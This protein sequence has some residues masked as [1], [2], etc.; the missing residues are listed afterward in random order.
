MVNSNGRL[1]MRILKRNN[2]VRHFC[3]SVNS[4]DMQTAKELYEQVG[5][6]IKNSLAKTLDCA[7]ERFAADKFIRIEKIEIDLGDIPRT[8]LMTMLPYLFEQKIH[9]LFSGFMT[10]AWERPEMEGVEVLDEQTQIIQYFTHFL[11]YGTIPWHLEERMETLSF[12]DVLQVVISSGSNAYHDAF[13][14]MLG[15]DQARKR[16]LPWVKKVELLQILKSSLDSGAYQNILKFK[17][18]LSNMVLSAAS[19]EYAEKLFFTQA[20]NEFVLHTA[21]ELYKK[22]K[23]YSLARLTDEFVTFLS[24]QKQLTP[25]KWIKGWIPRM[26]ID[27]QTSRFEADYTEDIVEQILSHYTRSI[28]VPIIPHYDDVGELKRE[29]LVMQPETGAGFTY[30]LQLVY[31]E[32]EKRIPTKHQQ[33][34]KRLA[35][36][37]VWEALRVGHIAQQQFDACLVSLSKRI[38]LIIPLDTHSTA[39]HVIN[40]SSAQKTKLGIPNRTNSKNTMLEAREGKKHNLLKSDDKMPHG[41]FGEATP[42][43]V[44]NNSVSEIR[45]NKLSEQEDAFDFLLARDYWALFIRAGITPFFK[46]YREPVKRLLDL[47]AKYLYHASEDVALVIK[48]SSQ[49]NLA[50]PAIWIRTYFG[51]DLYA[52]FIKIVNEEINIL[53]DTGNEYER[54]ILTHFFRSGTFPWPEVQQ[55]GKEELVTIVTTFFTPANRKLLVETLRYTHFF[56]NANAM[57]RVYSQLP[58]QLCR[59][60]TKIR[61]QNF[62]ETQFVSGEQE[63][64]ILTHFLRSGVFPIPEIQQKGKEFLVNIVTT[65][66]APANRQLLIET[67][68]H[69]RFFEDASVVKLVFDQLPLQLCRELTKIR[70][71]NFSESY[72]AILRDQ[73]AIKQQSKDGIE[74]PDYEAW[75]TLD[76]IATSLIDFKEKR[77]IPGYTPKGHANLLFIQIKMQAQKRPYEIAAMLVGLEK[78]F[79]NHLLKAFSKPQKEFIHKLVQRYRLKFVSL[80]SEIDEAEKRDNELHIKIEDSGKD[81]ASYF[82]NNAGLVLLNPYIKRL[83]TRFELTSNKTFVSDFAREKAMHILQYIATG[84]DKHPEHQMALNKVLVGM[85]IQYPMRY[86]IA[87]NETEKD[88][89]NG[90]LEAII[91][92]WGALK[93]TSVEGLRASFFLRE[94]N[95]TKEPQ[96]W[97]LRVDKKAYDVLLAKL[98]WG[99]AILHMPWMQIPLYT[100]WEDQ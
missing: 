71:L 63:L 41:E 65:F 98:P 28:V 31:A 13:F 24:E 30:F 70:D 61:N 19:F 29:L 58:L 3:A 91:Q 78:E 69:T 50:L 48:N 10:G 84:R 90:L 81:N 22:K 64:A 17:T 52:Q 45:F 86:D 51:N 8:E 75:M 99:Y 66:F 36:G 79:V 46:V 21:A 59:E 15:L 7:C 34:V 42:G 23:V 74:Y 4:P 32:I 2:R 44:P 60:L 94:G 47:F 96:G 87:L 16:L 57:E 92:N 9:Q 68:R 37:E 43:D 77:I 6:L 5:F 20:L 67:L 72:N 55:I 33:L 14:E 49:D 100:D 39:R 95:L 12:Q 88:V 27:S 97:R 83:F 89:C 80:A 35:A 38:A 56:E 76:E 26:L 54:V 85:P 18:A 40:L 25:E 62:T 82:V 93:N 11:K 73:T 1:A 53:L